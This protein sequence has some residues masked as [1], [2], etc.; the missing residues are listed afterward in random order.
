[1]AASPFPDPDATGVIER[2]ARAGLV[3]LNDEQNG[4]IFLGVA[5][6]PDVPEVDVAP[7]G[8]AVALPDAVTLRDLP[9]L[10]TRR[11]PLV[12]AHKFVKLGDRILLVRPEDRM[13]VAEIPRYRLAP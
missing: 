8:P 11:I 3:Q 9:A 12:S 13:V 7:P 10:V 5:N 2:S 6:L 1:M 4:W